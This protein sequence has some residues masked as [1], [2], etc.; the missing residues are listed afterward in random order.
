FQ[1][2]MNFDQ[3]ALEFVGVESGLADASNFG[4]TMVN[5]GVLT[6]SWN[7]DEAKRLATG[8]VVFSLTFKA[9][10]SGRLSDMFNI[11]SSYTVA[12]AYNSNSELLNVALSFN[13]NLVSGAFD[14][15]QNTPNPFASVT[16]IGFYLPEATSATLTISDVQ[17]KVVKVIKVQDAAKGYNTVKLNRSELGASGVLSYRLDT[18]SNSATRKMILV[19]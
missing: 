15:Y 10:E 13:N 1:F 12:E 6:A 19:D 8:D 11:S 3:K 4:T 2:S 18:D 9:N 17:G 7:S 14:L 5:E 16:T